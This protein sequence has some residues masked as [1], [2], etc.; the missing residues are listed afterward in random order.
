MK[1]VIVNADDFGISKAVNRG[2]IEAFREGILTSASFMSNMP[3]FKDAVFHCRKNDNLGVGIHLNLNLGR[4]LLP[5]RQV[6]TLV[7]SEGLFLSNYYQFIKL[8]YLKKINLFEIE[9]EFRT[10][11]EKVKNE[12]IE[13]DHINSHLHVHMFPQIFKIVIRLAKE[14]SIPAIRFSN[15]RLRFGI[16]NNYYPLAP[17]NRQQ[18]GRYFYD[19]RKVLLL[20]ILAG[21]DKKFLESSGL[22]NPDYFFGAFL[23]GQMRFE[24][25]VK[26]FDIIKDSCTEIACHPGYVDDEIIATNDSLIE[27]REEELKTLLDPKLKQAILEKDITLVTFAEISKH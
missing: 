11:I 6:K 25:Y 12:N 21:F 20:K 22:Y 14:Y 10:Q 27:E 16:A 19:F 7:N 24:Q 2:I 18:I 3:A 4:P 13:L 9:K 1:K 17:R 8:L 5:P 23:M 26:I 15:E